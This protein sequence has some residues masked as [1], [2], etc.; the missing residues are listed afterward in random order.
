MA[1]PA[2]PSDVELLQLMVAGSEDAFV[3]LYRR[4][5]NRVYRF[6]LQMS[7]SATIAEDV[8]QEVFMVLMREA[9][10]YDAARGALSTYL[11]G[12]ARNYVLRYLGR[13]RCQI[14][15]GDDAED[16]T[17]GGAEEGLIV[18]DDPLSELARRE[19]IE[20]V[21]AAVL[22]LPARYREVVVLCDLHEMSYA[23]ASAV[24]D[25]AVG[26]IRSR[27]HRGRA[28]LVVKLRATQQQ[29]QASP[30]VNS[31]RCLA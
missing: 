5:E 30:K 28:L 11:Y 4:H 6:A 15:I 8:T 24:L 20:Q 7:G 21:R 22:A 19:M 12:V 27:L 26:T 2:T 23:E 29:D 1:D 18:R 3:T 13:D 9:V 25:C 10:R 31:A 14:Q 17:S 16:D